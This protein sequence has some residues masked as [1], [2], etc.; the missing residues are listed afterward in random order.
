MKTLTPGEVQALAN[1]LRITLQQRT[2]C[3]RHAA[4]VCLHIL[5]GFALDDADQNTA[6]AARGLTNAAAGLA[7]KI[8]RGAFVLRQS[9]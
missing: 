3:P 6:V 5:A 9:H 4:D 8:R 1:E 7:S 2:C